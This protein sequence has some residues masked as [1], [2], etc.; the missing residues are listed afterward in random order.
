MSLPLHPALT[1]TL[2]G[3]VNRHQQSVI[4]YL[5]AENRALREQLASRRL[6]WTDAQRRRLAEKAKTVGR[7]ALGQLGTIVTPD[8]LLRWYRKLVAAKYDG[9]C[10]RRGKPGRP[11][12]RQSIAELVTDM[13]RGNPSWGYTRIRGAL[14]NLGHEGGRNTIKR[15]RCFSITASSPRPNAAD[16]LPGAR[17]SNHISAPSRECASGCAWPQTQESRLRTCPA[18]GLFLLLSCRRDW[19]RNRTVCQFAAPWGHPFAGSWGQ[20]GSRNDR[21]E[22]WHI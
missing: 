6:R 20:G 3:W 4:E 9:S 5:Q 21:A 22:D 13:A 11:R 12:T 1:L 2:S 7:D 8:T 19:F 10:V 17:S 14:Y 16:G 15:V 18:T